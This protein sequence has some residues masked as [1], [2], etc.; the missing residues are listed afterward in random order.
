M[1]LT[2][3]KAVAVDEITKVAKPI[4]RFTPAQRADDRKLYSM[5]DMYEA[6]VEA[7]VTVAQP[8]QPLGRG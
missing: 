8:T 6:F 2:I 4:V 3:T 1:D 5:K 7:P